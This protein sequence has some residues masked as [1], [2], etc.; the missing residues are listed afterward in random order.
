MSPI[1]L[2]IL[3]SGGGTN[4][5]AIIDSIEIGRVTARIAVVISN[6]SKAWAL[7]RARHHGIPAIHVSRPMF[8][9][10]EELDRAIFRT[11]Q[12]HRVELVILAGYMKKIGLQTIRAYRNRILNTHPAL[13]PAF[14]GHGMYGH[15]VHEAVL[16]S[17]ATV[18]GVTIH[19]VD[20]EYDHGPI[21]AQRTVPV[22]SGDTP[23]TLAARVLEQEHLLYPQV[24]QWFAEGRVRVEGGQVK[25]D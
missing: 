15:H 13:L 21:V 18:S 7:V 11:L 2:G 9:S 25:V 12:E 24:I 16:A 6:N 14:G 22:L 20:E 4:L 5:Q 8:S 3:A 23:E 10:E 17:G 19:L 1:I